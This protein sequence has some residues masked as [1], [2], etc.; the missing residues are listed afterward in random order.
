MIRFKFLPTLLVILIFS[1]DSLLAQ[2][3]KVDSLGF[4]TFEMTEADTSYLMKKYFLVLLKAGE[5]RDHSPEEAAE[6]QKGHMENMN[7]IAESGQL[8]I[9]GPMGEDGPL[10]GIM[11]LAVPTKEAAEIL[12]KDDPAVIAG[13][14]KYEIHPWWAAKGSKLN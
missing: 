14:L 2:E 11:I 8:N 6:I 7:K 12:L 9:A 4:E 13:R 5:N 10:R 3:L 1:T